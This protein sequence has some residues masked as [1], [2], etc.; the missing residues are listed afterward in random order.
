MGHIT[1]PPRGFSSGRG[2]EIGARS[3]ATCVS[4]AN[5]GRRA[6]DLLTGSLSGAGAKAKATANMAMTNIL[7]MP[8][9]YPPIMTEG[10]RPHVHHHQAAYLK[11]VS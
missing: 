4:S 2:D 6:C 9:I 7:C 1:K 11:R 3:M 10:R 5:C 8:R